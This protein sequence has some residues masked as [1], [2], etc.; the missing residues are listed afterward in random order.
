MVN[1]QELYRDYFQNATRTIE[2]LDVPVVMKD[3]IL[4]Y[5]S[6]IE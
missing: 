1:Y 2:H 6:N 3:I 4:E 5:F